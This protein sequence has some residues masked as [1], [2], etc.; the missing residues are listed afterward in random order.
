VDP[1]YVKR[2][3]LE[4]PPLRGEE[5][6]VF[7]VEVNYDRARKFGEAIA[8]IIAKMPLD[9]FTDERYYPPA[10]ADRET[11]SMYFLVMV[12]M[13]HRLSRPHKPYEGV[14]DGEFYHGADLLYRLGAKAL[15]EDPDF[16]TAD[17]LARISEDDVRRW[18]GVRSNNKVIEP[19]DTHL[20]ALLLRDLGMKLKILFNGSAY[21]LIVESGGF[22]KDK[23][24]GGFI[25]LLKV[26]RAYQDPVEKKAYL[27][28]KFLERRGVLRVADPHN[29]EVPV[30]NHLTRIALRL[31]LVNVDSDTLES[32]AYGRP[33]TWEEDVE[34]RLAVRMA[35]KEAARAG[36]LDPFILDDFLW[37]FGRK[38]C[39]RDS[40][41][42]RAGCRDDCRRLGVCNAGNCV[43]ASLCRAYEDPRYLVPEHNYIDTWYY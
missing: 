5:V 16:F 17:R 30:D 26:F 28:A 9:A 34:L 24:G 39:T 11:V 3:C 32:I 25:N 12:A 31:G 27:L 20:R 36:G 15:S 10:T 21:N 8:P 1:R 14:V 18:L 35:Y 40:P 29:K 4:S 33:F 6:A 37:L 22:L 42:C 2:P 7:S 13:D 19:P 38:C 23:W 41:V 43:L